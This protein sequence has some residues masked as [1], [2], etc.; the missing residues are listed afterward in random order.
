MQDREDKKH[1]HGGGIFR[2]YYTR[3]R[4]ASAEYSS[5]GACLRHVDLATALREVLQGKGVIDHA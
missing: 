5:G 2:H 4:R 1:Q 3:A